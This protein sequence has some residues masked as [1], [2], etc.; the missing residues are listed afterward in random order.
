MSEKLI[1][2]RDLGPMLRE[3]EKINEEIYQFSH[4]VRKYQEE[5]ILLFEIPCEIAPE[6][7][8]LREQAETAEKIINLE[9]I[10]A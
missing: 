4:E 2:D 5:E 6:K 9:L 7:I 3:R 1:E 10:I 8:N